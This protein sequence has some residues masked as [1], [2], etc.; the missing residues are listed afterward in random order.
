MPHLQG[1]AVTNPDVDQSL[2]SSI[3]GQ[4]SMKFRGTANRFAAVPTGVPRFAV[5]GPEPPGLGRY[6]RSQVCWS[7]YLRSQ[8]LNRNRAKGDE[9]RLDR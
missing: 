8:V 1:V 3:C 9:R 4:M 7:C 2:D 6:R 5:Q